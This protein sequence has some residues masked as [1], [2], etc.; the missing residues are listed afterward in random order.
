MLYRV[1]LGVQAGTAM[2]DCFRPRRAD[3][4]QDRLVTD[5]RLTRPVAADRPKHPMFDEV[6]LRRSGGIM[7]YRDGQVELVGQPLQRHLPAPLAVVGGPTAVR[8]NQQ[9]PG[10]GVATAANVQPPATDRR[11]RE[12]RGVVRRADQNVAV[13]V[14]HIVD[15]DRDGLAG[16][17]TGVVV[18][19]HGA[20]ALPPAA[21]GVLE[22]ADPLLLLGIDANNWQA[23][24]YVQP[25]QPRQVTKLPIPVEIPNPC[26]AFAV[27]PQAEAE[28]TQQAGNRGWRQSDAASPQ[29]PLDLAERAVRPLQPGDRVSGRGILKQF[30]E[31]LQE[32][33][34][35][36][37]ARGWPAPGRRIRWAGVGR[38]CCNSRWPRAMVLGSKPV[39]RAR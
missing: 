18:V 22:V 30:F 5:Q 32:V 6:P 12:G 10:V 33:R 11:H 14:C 3:V 17:P 26:Q 25:T 7:G 9:P 13:L 29:R 38:A 8:R 37:S 35:F 27:G 15:A 19:E 21:A 23:K 16:C 24:S 28:T 1:L 20:V 39:I 31:N 34:T 36:F 2:P 4:L